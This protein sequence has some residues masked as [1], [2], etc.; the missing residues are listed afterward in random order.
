MSIIDDMSI[1]D[2]VVVMVSRSH[3]LYCGRGTPH[4]VCHDCHNLS[5]KEL[6]SM[7][8]LPG[9]SRPAETC[10]DVACPL[11]EGAPPDRLTQGGMP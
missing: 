9:F 7:R 10:D 2:G 1:V 6:R 3:C 5:D 11:W 4:E 8:W